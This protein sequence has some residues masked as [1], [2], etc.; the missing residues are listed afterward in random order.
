M[1]GIKIY[2]T[3]RIFD[4]CNRDKRKKKKQVK[5]GYLQIDFVLG[6]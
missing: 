4:Y 5:Q 6:R 2:R 3:N 1:G